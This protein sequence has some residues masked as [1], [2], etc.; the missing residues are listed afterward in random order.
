V[1]LLGLLHSVA[2]S[3]TIA[4]PEG[5]YPPQPD[6]SAVP[7]DFVWL[8]PCYWNGAM[9]YRS[10]AGE[11]VPTIPERVPYANGD[12]CL[13]RPARPLSAGTQ[14]EAWWPDTEPA[15]E[16]VTA[17]PVRDVD[18]NPVQFTTTSETTPRVAGEVSVVRIER[19]SGNGGN[20]CDPWWEKEVHLD[21]SPL[22]GEYFELQ[23]TQGDD[24]SDAQ[25]VAVLAASWLA[26]EC[27][28]YGLP[29]NSPSL[30]RVRSI[31]GAAEPSPW[32]LFDER[33]GQQAERSCSAVSGHATWFLLPAL[34]MVRRRRARGRARLRP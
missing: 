17:S 34:A 22:D 33:A 10:E 24:F 11:V 25:T 3:C 21:R 30:F 32:R 1:I 31:L 7:V 12:V 20:S 5:L 6:F 18:G 23:F 8:R 19:R 9:E 26:G 15:F 28:H 2:L 14:W 13:Q 16:E 29:R 4:C 27:G